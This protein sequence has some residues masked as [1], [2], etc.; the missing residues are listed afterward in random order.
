[1]TI[2]HLSKIILVYVIFF[3][4]LPINASNGS[5]NTSMIQCV[6]N[7]AKEAGLIIGG[8]TLVAMTYGILNDHITARLC[9][10]YF[11]EGFHRGML[12]RVDNRLFN[13]MK[14]CKSPNA[15]AFF[16]E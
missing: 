7:E 3:M 16:W 10:E 1:M 12:L 5:K 15:I 2:K 4:N 8:T 9:K 11:T 6:R 14:T 13:Y